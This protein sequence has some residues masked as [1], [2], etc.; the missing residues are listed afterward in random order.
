MKALKT[1]LALGV[2]M[3]VSATSFA[4]TTNPLTSLK[5]TAKSAATK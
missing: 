1:L 4:D 2:A 3:T 5:D